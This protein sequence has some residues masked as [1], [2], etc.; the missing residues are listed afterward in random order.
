MGFRVTALGRLFLTGS[1]P[2]FLA[3]CGNG[4][5]F[6]ASDKLHEN[7]GSTNLAECTSDSL[8]TTACKVSSAGVAVTA[9]TTNIT[10]ANIKSGTTIF[11]VTGS[12]QSL[13]AA[14]TDENLNSAACSAASNRYVTPTLG[15]NVNGAN[16][17]LVTVIPPGYY[18]GTRSVTAS[19]TNLVA[20][21]IRSGTSLF[22]VTGTLS[23]MLAACT[24]DALN[25]TACSTAANRYVTAKAGA[26]VVGA[27]SALVTPI[28]SGYYDGTRTVT[29]RDANLVAA[30]IR[31]GTNVFGVTGTLTEMLAACTDDTVNSSACSTAANRYVASTAGSDITSFTN[32]SGTTTVTAAIANGYYNGKSCLITDSDLLAANIKNGVEIFG[33]TGT[34]TGSGGGTFS[35]YMASTQHHTAGSTQL[36]LQQES[37]DSAGMSYYNNSANYRAVPSISGKDND[38]TSGGSVVYV[39]RSAW[40]L[41]TCGASGTL[42]AR[43]TD[44][45]NHATI[46]PES[47]WDGAVKGNAGQGSWSLVSRTGAVSSGRGREVWRDNRTGLLW[48]SLV[49]NGTITWCRASGSNNITGNPTAEAGNGNYCT[50]ASNQNTGTYAG[51][52][53]AVSVCFED[54]DNYFTAGT[55]TDAGGKAGLSLSSTPVVSWRLPTLYDYKLADVNGIRFVMNDM[56]TYNGGKEWTATLYSD[57]AEY[58]KEAYAYGSGYGEVSRGPLNSA[59]AARCVGR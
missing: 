9:N 40:G 30:N 3:A 28:P 50:D 14:C 10:A 8:T 13:L 45:Q 38:G 6:A 5:G 17:A 55:A 46:G 7:T 56:G 2:L 41:A 57:S 16:A 23:E 42:A 35:S 21:N 53:K 11:G 37:A 33:V 25:S 39:N 48:S 12:L 24:N 19:D 44:C 15:L 4:S 59:Y 27:N 52:V 32:S 26:D 49:S 1:L 58:V 18:D 22:G 51:G 47:T 29:A 36:T 43:I 20:A 34:Y 54:G 31:S